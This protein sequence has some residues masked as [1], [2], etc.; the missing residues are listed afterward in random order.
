MCLGSDFGCDLPAGYFR[1]T[2]NQISMIA[3]VGLGQEVY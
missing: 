2:A 3:R 1:A